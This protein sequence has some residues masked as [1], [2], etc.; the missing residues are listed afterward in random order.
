MYSAFALLL[1]TGAFWLMVHFL[2]AEPET[3]AV[4]SA[5]SMKLHGAA[6]LL[7]TFLLG[8]IWSAHIRHAWIR[9]RNRLWG[10]FFGAAVGLLVATGYGL[11][12]FNGEGL[13]SLTE[14]LHWLGGVAMG[15]LYWVH[16]IAGRRAVAGRK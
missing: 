2:V 13:R 7:G 3:Q 6:A 4:W 12:Y 1:L 10:G 11:Y 16:L 9:R 5:W 8:M 15:G 14:W